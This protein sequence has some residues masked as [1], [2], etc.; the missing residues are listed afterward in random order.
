MV[1]GKMSLIELVLSGV[2]QGTVL[3]PLLF[4]LY[5]NDLELCINHFKLKLF[6]D[7]S[8]LNKSLH[9]TCYEDGCN[10]LQNDLESC[11]KWAKSNNMVLQIIKLFSYNHCTKK[12]FFS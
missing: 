11:L 6:A 5:V 3:G 9:P 10:D 7:D 4:L 1:N 8:R 12:T 2:P